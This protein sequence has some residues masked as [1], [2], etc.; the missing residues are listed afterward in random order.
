MEGVVLQAVHDLASVAD[1]HEDQ[2]I[3]RQRRILHARTCLD[4][5][6][7]ERDQKVPR[8]GGGTVPVSQSVPAQHEFRKVNDSATKEEIALF[9]YAISLG[10][11]LADKKLIDKTDIIRPEDFSGD[12]LRELVKIFLNICDG[13]NE[14]LYARMSDYFSRLTING[15]PAEDVML[16]A[17]ETADRCSDVKVKSDMYLA[18]LFK[19]RESI[20]NR[21]EE[22]LINLLSGAGEEEKKKINDMLRRISDYK[23]KLRNRIGDL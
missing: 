20:L 4:G 1:R 10:S 14:T 6:I 9:G 21:E 23:L 12:T 17:V 16:K 8:P 19:V 18:L 13:R 22:R 7:P 2:E 11:A 15:M 3:S 5:S